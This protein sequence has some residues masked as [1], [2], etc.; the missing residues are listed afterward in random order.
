MLLFL[1]KCSFIRMCH[2]PLQNILQFIDS[3]PHLW[4]LSSI[5]ILALETD[6]ACRTFFICLWQSHRSAWAHVDFVKGLP[7]FL[8]LLGLR[9]G[10]AG[11]SPEAG[12]RVGVGHSFPWGGCPEALQAASLSLFCPTLLPYFGPI[13]HPAA[14]PK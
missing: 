5:F 14:L 13:Q 1:Q 11:R 12:R 10:G 3:F 8:A 6:R 7:C 9:M 4:M 2:I